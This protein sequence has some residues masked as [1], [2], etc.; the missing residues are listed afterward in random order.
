MASDPFPEFFPSD[1]SS[2]D[3]RMPFGEH[4]EELRTCL[5]RALLGVLAGTVVCLTFGRQIVEIICYPLL[6]VQRANGLP[7]H[8]QALSP[9][10]AFAAYL[11]IGLLSGL[12]LAMPW[13]L[14]QFWAFTASGL[15]PRERHFVKQLVPVSCGLFVV[16][17]F[18]LYVLAL[19]LI[20]QFF[21]R[22]N[23]TFEMPGILPSAAD[24]PG[25]PSTAPPTFDGEAMRVP[26]LAEDPP[27]PAAGDVWVNTARGRLLVQSTEGR[28]SV[29]LTRGVESPI[30]QSE[31]AV[32]S[33]L[34]FVLM[35]ALA[36]GAAFETPVVVFFLAR[37]GLV[38]VETMVRARRYVLLVVV[39]VAA[40]MTPPDV[41]SQLLLAAPMY[42]LFELGLLA[43]RV[44]KQ[45]TTT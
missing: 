45:K 27:H 35:L 13:V 12:I 2:D 40:V 7:P 8:L 36:F 42:G 33:Y 24:A 4:L 21:I 44:K 30:M 3:A 1:G 14:Y 38:P 31:F 16:G 17:V 25:D 34:S 11:K 23:Q 32:D 9:T 19:P 29:P 6:I 22:F 10:S 39:I 28:L 5:I 43:A 18:F 26:I 37:T 15:L 20:L 41:V